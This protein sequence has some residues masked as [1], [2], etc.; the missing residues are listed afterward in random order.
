MITL[1][2]NGVTHDV[3]ESLVDHFL[4]SGWQEV[5]IVEIP[6]TPE[7]PTEQTPE[8]PKKKAKK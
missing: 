5:E 8:E 6:E 3:D 2:K 1:T 7:E 4:D